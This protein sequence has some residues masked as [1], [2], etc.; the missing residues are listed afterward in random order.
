V[1][2]EAVAPT[3]QAPAL[4]EP[5]AK[6][7]GP[8]LVTTFRVLDG[9]AD[10]LGMIA[11][12]R[13]TS[14]ASAS[15]A[16]HAR[17]AAADAVLDSLPGADMTRSAQLAEAQRLICALEA[18]RKLVAKHSSMPLLSD[19]LSKQREADDSGDAFDLSRAGAGVN[20]AVSA[21]GEASATNDR[22]GSASVR[23]EAATNAE[24]MEV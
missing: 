13:E 5:R 14:V 8:D 9:M 1:L 24:T 10:I 7:A 6:V 20:A 11:E 22:D 17:F 23:T 15:A 2:S 19:C 12:G 21:E 3:M 4:S 16:L 18:K